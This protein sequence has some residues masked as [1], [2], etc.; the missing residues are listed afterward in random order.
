MIISFSWLNLCKVWHVFFISSLYS[1][2]FW[3]IFLCQDNKLGA[4]NRLEA[5]HCNMKE[6]HCNMGRL[7]SPIREEAFPLSVITCLADISVLISFFVS[8][9]PINILPR[10]C[11]RWCCFWSSSSTWS[12]EGDAKSFTFFSFA[13]K[14][15]SAYH[16]NY[17]FD[18][19]YQLWF[20]LAYL[21]LLS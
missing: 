19:N 12:W 21:H 4:L 17:T 8:P 16:A 13:I 11:R 10:R 3:S 18:Y 2:F 20:W 7:V 6:K 9:K 5:K 1:L 14:W 15:F